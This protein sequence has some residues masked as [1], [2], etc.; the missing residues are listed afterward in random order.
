MQTK[1]Y[2]FKESIGLRA[3]NSIFWG[4]Q[5]PVRGPT[6]KAMEPHASF[7]MMYIRFA[8]GHNPGK[9]ICWFSSLRDNLRT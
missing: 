9:S 2:D 4:T 6:E 8:L 3:G 7:G 5:T 1:C